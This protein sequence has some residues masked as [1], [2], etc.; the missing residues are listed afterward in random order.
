[1]TVF[2]EAVH[3]IKP[4]TGEAFDRFVDF[5][6][7]A[8]VPAMERSG[9]DLI[10]AWKRTGGAM[11][12]DVVLI[13][14]ENMA[15]YE[16]AAASLQSDAGLQRGLALLGSGVQLA[17]T[18]KAVTPVPYA[19]EARLEKALEQRPAKPRQYM[20]AV[21]QVTM[22]GAPKA[23]DLIGKLA[24]AVESGGF[25]RLATA[26]TTTIGQRGE[27]TDI[28]AMTNGISN[29]DYRRAGPSPLGGLIED[30][31]SVAPEESIYYLNPLP[32]S[33]LQ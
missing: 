4:L 10:G 14:F 33:K 2:L 13:R 27:L 6:T 12:Q 29:F 17:E 3:T 23:Y 21:L 18:V 19:T 7:N 22:G 26:Y 15:A 5:Y 8:V 24:D 11:N 31:R 28:W 16:K 1:M 30:L 9:F 32:Y 20:Q 25:M